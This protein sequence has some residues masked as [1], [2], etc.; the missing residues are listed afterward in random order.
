MSEQGDHVIYRVLVFSRDGTEIL[1]T[2]SGSGLQFPEVSIPE[3]ERVAE[4]V[5]YAIEKQWGEVVVCLFEPDWP[6]PDESSRY[7]VARHWRTCESSS[8]LLRWIPISDLSDAWFS[9]PGDVR[10]VQ[11]SLAR[12][13]VPSC[14][15]DPG[16]FAHLNWFEELCEWAAKAINSRGLCLTGKFRQLN[17]NAS[18]SLIRFETNGPAV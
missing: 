11:E 10:L 3:W 7:M 12:C 13:R 9:V 1:L 2:R 5:T 18:F 17:A 15:T 4:K 6:L 8:A 14:E 16:L